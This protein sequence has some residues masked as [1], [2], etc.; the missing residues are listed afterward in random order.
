MYDLS[1]PLLVRGFNVL[2]SYLDKTEAFATERKI[3]PEI[4]FNARLAPD[5]MSFA[6]QIQRAS[7]NAKNGVARIAGIEAPP[8]PDTETTF[9]DLRGRIAKTIDWLKTVKPDQIDGTEAKVVPFKAGSVDATLRADTYLLQMLLPN[10]YFHVTTA[11]DILRHNHVPL[12]KL[13][14][15][16]KVDFITFTS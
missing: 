3:A 10:F 14:F 13:D 1:V 8:M 7:D 15:F 11:H 16:D 12:G 4:F 5:M 9:D 2:S 6:N